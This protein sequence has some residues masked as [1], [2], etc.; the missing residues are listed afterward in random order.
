[1][2]IA[3]NDKNPQLNDIG[4]GNTV[5]KILNQPEDVASLD[6]R[7]SSSL[8]KFWWYGLSGKPAKGPYGVFPAIVLLVFASSMLAPISPEISNSEFNR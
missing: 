6:W 7:Q 4:S 2:S 1:M 3:S 8:R 5:L